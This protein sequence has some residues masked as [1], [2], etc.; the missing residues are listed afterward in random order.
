MGAFGHEA[1]GP[2]TRGEYHTV[3]AAGS[4]SRVVSGVAAADGVRA[5]A[6]YLPVLDGLRAVCILLVVLS[7]LGLDHVVPGAF[8]VTLFFFISGFLITRQ[9]AGGLARE[10][11]V[12]FAG[13]YLRRALRLM[14]ACLAYIGVAG[15]L[16]RAEGGRISAGGW[17]AALLYGANYYDLWAGYRSVVAGVRHP[18]NILW[19]LAIEEHFYAVWPVALALL[20]RAR[21]ALWVVLGL[22]VVVLLWRLWIWD[23]CFAAG[24]PWVCGPENANPLWRFNRLY[25]ATDARIDS[26]AWGVVLALLPAAAVRRWPGWAAA[27]GACAL[28]LSFALPG[29]FGRHVLRPSVQGAALLGVVPWLLEG[30]SVVHRAL[31]SAPA[32]LVGR[33]SYS[34]YLWHWAALGVADRLYPRFGMAWVAV[35]V[36]LS[37]GLAAASYGGIERPMLVVRRRFGSRAVG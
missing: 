36:V 34:L 35:A 15:L 8:G 12:D 37:G 33:M 5:A 7:H 28:V 27:A 9:L 14:P 32:L 20:W 6:S 19:S 24:A 4:S 25:L 17:L 26:L 10:G 1:A 2:A 29:A 22:C 3:A 13:F 23:A 31:R 11:R 18:F 16:Y 21:A 30:E